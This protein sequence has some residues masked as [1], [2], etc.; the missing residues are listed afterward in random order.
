MCRWDMGGPAGGYVIA[1]YSHGKR[2]GHWTGFYPNG[3]ILS[4]S[5]WID[6]ERHGHHTVFN[7]DGSIE[8]EE[9]WIHG[10]RQKKPAALP[11]AP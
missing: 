7:R 6:D 2:N 5:D 1:E 11:L 9:D 8:F 3:T 10:V 4:E